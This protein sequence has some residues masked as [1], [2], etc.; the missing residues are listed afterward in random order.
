[1]GTY[2]GACKGFYLSQSR[3][4]VV[5]L[6][7]DLP[8]FIQMIIL[9]HELGHA[10]LHKK[11]C[12]LKAFHEFSLF[13][14]TSRMEYEANIFLAEFMMNDT[15]VLE[16]LNE[17]MSFFDAAKQLCVPPE[18]LDFKFRVLKRKGYMVIDSPMNARSNFLKNNLG[19][20][21]SE[22]EPC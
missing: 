7:S 9:I 10:V 15:D 18:L 11:T 13:D 14:D 6:N 2:E 21:D 16:L 8:S 17:D 1:M 3:V 12:G 19:G 5:T 20:D 4:Q 22:Y